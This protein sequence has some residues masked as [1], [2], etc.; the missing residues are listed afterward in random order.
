MARWVAIIPL[1]LIL[2]LG[3]IF[4]LNIG[5]DSSVIPSALIDKPVPDFNLPPLPG[6]ETS[7][8]SG[9]FTNAKV[10][11]LNVFASWCVPCRAEHP[12]IAQLAKQTGIP[13]YGL[14]YK[15]RNPEDGG[16]WLEEL[17][18][19][20]TSV[21]MDLSGRTGIDFGVYGVP[22]TFIIDG[23]GHIRYKHVGPVT[24]TH[25][26]EEFLPRIAELQGQ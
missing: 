8:S 25:L 23:R 6:R 26:Q 17:G 9:D 10:S 15:E 1:A 21:G 3:V 12:F 5:R 14:N 22:E 2:A 7:L 20:Y 19:P 24:L 11:V 4:A 18:D 16:K 13:V